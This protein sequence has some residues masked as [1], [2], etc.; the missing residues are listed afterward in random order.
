MPRILKWLAIG[1]VTLLILAIAFALTMPR[2]LDSEAIRAAALQQLS[3]ATGGQW[4]FSHLRLRWLPVP[5]VSAAGASFR[6]PDTIEV[7]AE[8]LTLT[9]ALLP[10]LWGEIRLN[11]VELVAPDLTIVVGPT[12][13]TAS[14]SPFTVSDLRAALARLSRSSVADLRLLEIIIERGRVVLAASDRESLTL[15]EI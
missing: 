11:R 15:S 2:L 4:Q 1:A 12:A 7:K 5:T 14:P 13:A 3:R 9:T 10:L 6:I 8:S